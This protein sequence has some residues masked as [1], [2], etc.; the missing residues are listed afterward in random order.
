MS[1]AAEHER[2]KAAARA[3]GKG[4]LLD[5]HKHTTRHRAELHGSAQAGCFYCC[6]IFSSDS[7]EY[8]TDDDTTALCP[9]CDIDSVIGEASG[10]PVTDKA[11]LKEMNEFWF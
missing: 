2:K 3:S 1:F 5:A 7:I 11:F 8:W 4:Y 10:F 9:K 6:S